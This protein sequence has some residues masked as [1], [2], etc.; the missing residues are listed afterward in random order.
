MKKN[1]LILFISLIL[2]SCTTTS[3][4]VE[5]NRE[6]EDPRDNSWLIPLNEI[7]DGGPGKDG[8]PSIDRPNFISAAEVDFLN[9][10]DLVI[11]IIVN[12]EVRAYPHIVMDWH[13]VVN[14]NIGNNFFTLNYCPLTGTAF[15]WESVTNGIRSTFGVSGLLYNANLIMY[16][17]NTDSN[18]SQLGLECVNGELIGDKP[19]LLNVVETDWETWSALYPS[20]QVLSTNTGFSRNYGVSPYGDYATNND[21]FIFR[22]AITNAALPNKDRVYCIIDG[23]KSK[24]YEF[25]SFVGG[26]AIKDSFNGKNYLIIGNESVINAFE[27]PDQFIDTTF[28]YQL[29]ASSNSIIRDNLGNTWSLF[30]EA[31]SGPNLGNQLGEIKSVISYWFAIAAFYPNP[32]IYSEL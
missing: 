20:T 32:E 28:E 17:R 8:I 9:D 25:S 23:D 29:N 11:G 4:N 16:D 1:V 31:T 5:E 18:W 30:G 14:D 24:V 26:K 27:L 10:D 3:N 6:P 22:P 19:A 15:A 13:E 7:R 12:N 2:I 21:R